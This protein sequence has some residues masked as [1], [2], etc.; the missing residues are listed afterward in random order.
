M[1]LP[2][3]DQLKFHSYKDAKLLMEAIE[4]RYG[5]NK[6]SK[7]VQRTLLKKQYE[8]FAASSSETLDQTF[9]RL[10]K[11]ISQ[12]EIQENQVSDKV[13][14][15]LGYKAASPAVESFVNSSKMLENQENVMSRSDKGYHAVPPPYTGTYIPPKPDLMFIDEQ[16][17]NESVDVVSNVASSDVKTV[18]SKHESVDVKNKS[19]YSTVETKPVRKTTLVLQSLRIGILMM[20]GNP[21]QKEYKEK[22]VIDSGCSRHITGNKCYLTDYKDYDGGFVSFGDEY[23]AVASCCRQVLWIQNQMLDYGFNL[24]NTKIYIDNESTI[25]IVK[26]LVFHSKT[27]HIEIRHHF[28]RDSY[29]KKLIQVIKIYTDHNVAD[30]LTKA[31]DVGRFNFLVASIGLLNL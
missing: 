11:L 14:T 22:G 9:D 26:N 28:I 16:V 10:Q 25:C 6:E 21:Q 18:E 2:N 17:K 4:K 8:N 12:L 1:A 7:K 15:G 20:K 27:K 31:F 3:K 13:K 23:V 29:E 24:I 30:L 19:V 5:G